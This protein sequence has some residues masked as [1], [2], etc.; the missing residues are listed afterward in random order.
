[1]KPRSAR[2]ARKRGVRAARIRLG[3]G[4]VAPVVMRRE[5]P[6]LVEV[7]AAVT[8]VV[9]LMLVLVVVVVEIVVAGLVVVV[10]AEDSEVDGSGMKTVVSGGL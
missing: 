7:V 1:V 3:K 2:E 10:G 5:S 9:V 4:A 6:V 8:S